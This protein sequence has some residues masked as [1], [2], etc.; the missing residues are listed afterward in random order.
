MESEQISI[1]EEAPYKV[2]F[3]NNV[4]AGWKEKLCMRCIGEDNDI[5]VKDNISV[6]QKLHCKDSLSKIDGS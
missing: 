4:K 3:V 2:S 1:S 6:H 5:Y